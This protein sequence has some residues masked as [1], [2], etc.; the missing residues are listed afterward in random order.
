M[1]MNTCR[2]VAARIWCDPA[3]SHVVMDVKACEHI[4]A[5]LYSVTNEK[6]Y[7][8]EWSTGAVGNY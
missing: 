6:D 1:S 8:N 4:A 3:F 7:R 2:E 5:I